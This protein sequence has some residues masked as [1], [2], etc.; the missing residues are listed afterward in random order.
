MMVLPRPSTLP[1]VDSPLAIGDTLSLWPPRKGLDLR[2]DYAA[3]CHAG[4]I[5]RVEG[6]EPLR[7]IRPREI[8]PRDRTHSRGRTL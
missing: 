1:R 8:L 2:H 6:I 3:A 7:L 5:R 4:V